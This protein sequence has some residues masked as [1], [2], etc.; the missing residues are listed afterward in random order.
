M[1]DL[2]CEIID[3]RTISPLD[4]ETI[5][6]SISKTG[7]C[8]IVHEAPRSGGMG[9]EISAQIMEKALTSLK[10]PVLRVTGY[11]TVFPLYRA[12]NDYLPSPEKII[13]AMKEVMQF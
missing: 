9:A 8:I 4:T 13:H 2:S 3:V 10:A 11:D 12:E 5:I 7:R 1:V 6:N